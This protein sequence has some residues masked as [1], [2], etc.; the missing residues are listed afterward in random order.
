MNTDRLRSL[1][2]ILIAVVLVALFGWWS[3]QRFY[4]TPRDEKLATIDLLTTT[5]R[6]LSG[7]TIAVLVM[8]ETCSRMRIR[9]WVQR[10]SRST[11]HFVRG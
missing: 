6:V 1:A 7:I 11:T 9:H 4:V 3:V 5:L 8:R 10:T 2:P